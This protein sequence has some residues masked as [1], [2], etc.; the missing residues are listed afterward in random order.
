MKD[1]KDK[2]ENLNFGRQCRCRSVI[3][4]TKWYIKAPLKSEIDLFQILVTWWRC[5]M[6]NYISWWCKKWCWATLAPIDTSA[7]D[8][9][10]PGACR[11]KLRTIP[12]TPT[13]PTTLIIHITTISLHTAHA[14]SV[15][16]LY[17]ISLDQL[18]FWSY[19][20]LQL[21]QLKNSPQN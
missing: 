16:V 6:H 18:N 8:T 20:F 7:V 15:Y 14:P 10:L 4:L 17:F 12:T 19:L 9:C 2:V 1:K 13:M 11:A 3:I 21:L 5:R